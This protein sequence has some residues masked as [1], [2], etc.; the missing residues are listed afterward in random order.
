MVVDLALGAHTTAA[1]LCEVLEWDSDFWGFPVARVRG[2]TLTHQQAGHVDAWSLH[3]SIRC[4][5]FLSQLDNAN[6]TTMAEASGF[7]LIDIRTNFS[8]GSGWPSG[9]HQPTSRPL[10]VRDSHAEDVPVLRSITR[11][12]YHDTRFYRDA[13]FPRDRCRALYETW[14]E[15]SCEGYADVVLVAEAAQMPVGYVS[16]HLQGRPLSGTIG[17]VGVSTQVRDAGIGQTLVR[18]ALEWFSLQGA[19]RVSV[20][21]QGRNLPAQ[22]LYERCGFLLQSEQAWY[23]K[24]YTLSAA[25]GE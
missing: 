14:I 19:E 21:T 20:V 8:R 3:N 6:A 23:H 13:N 24:W 7:H 17:L 9:D 16:C 12:C 25:Q 1:A 10:L 2:N 5:Y 22:R 11:D 18:R 15:R 4:L